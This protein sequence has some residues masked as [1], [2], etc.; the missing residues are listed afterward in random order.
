MLAGLLHHQAL[1]GLPPRIPK[2]ITEFGFSAFATADE[3]DL[4]GAVFDAEV[5][6]EF[7]ALGGETAYMYGYEPSELIRELAQCDSWGNLTLLQADSRHR[8][9]APVA[10]FW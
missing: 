4:A 8:I 3:V 1:D 9:K 2:L 7:L 10:A 5:A 6:A